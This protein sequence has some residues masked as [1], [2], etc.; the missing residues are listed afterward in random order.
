M[1]RSKIPNKVRPWDEPKDKRLFTSL[2][3]TAWG[4]DCDEVK[5]LEAT[6]VG[7]IPI[8]LDRRCSLDFSLGTLLLPET[9]D[10]YRFLFV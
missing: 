9:S 2:F 7:P 5:S 8:H 1:S 4:C 6:M 3:A 10:F